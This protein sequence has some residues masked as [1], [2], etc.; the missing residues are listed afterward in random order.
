MAIILIAAGFILYCMLSHF[1]SYTVLKN[2]ILKQRKWDLNICCGNTD[3]GGINADIVRH[4][5]VPNF[6]LVKDIYNLPFKTGEFDQVL[7]SHTI[8]HVDDPARF[9]TELKR[10]GKE[11]TIVIPPLYDITA[12]LNFFEHKTL[13]FSFKKKH[14]FLPGH[15]R[16]PLS[17]FVHKYLGQSIEASAV[18]LAAIF[19]RL[20]S[21]VR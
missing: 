14:C 12:A 17:A 1:L 6:R 11:V 18:P 15:A 2:R 3:G 8:E 13:F 9:F 21:K 5:D 20:R 10:V 16:L 4:K 19:S 7:C